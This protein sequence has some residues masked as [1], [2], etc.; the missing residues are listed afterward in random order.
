MCLKKFLHRLIIKKLA[1]EFD[2]KFTSLGEYTEKYIAFSVPIQKEFTE[3]DKKGEEITKTTSYRL[4]FI[5]SV[6]FM[7]SLL[8]SLVN[9]NA[10]RIHKIKCKYEHNDQKCETCRIKY[11]NFKDDLIEYKCLC[12]NNSYQTSLMKS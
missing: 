3:T 6:K 7:A 8:S 5:D 2:K 11:T 1:E 9:N 4:Q 12:C 10:K